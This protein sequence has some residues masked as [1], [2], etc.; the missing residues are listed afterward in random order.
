MPGRRFL[1]GGVP[2]TENPYARFR[3]KPVINASGT[4][5][6][7][8]GCRMFPEAAAAMAAAAGTFVDLDMLLRNTG[9]HIAGLLGVEGALVTA[10]ASPAIIL[11]TAACIAGTDPFLRNR[12]PADPPEKSEVIIMRCHRNPYDNAVPTAGARFVE[13][14]DAIRTHGWE[15][16]GSVNERTAAV[17]FALHAEM[18]DASLSLKETIEIAHGKGVPV[19]VDAAAELPPKANLRD[20]AARGA[21]LVA[22]SGGKDIRGPQASGLL[23]G[24]K[25]LVEAALFNGAPHYGVGR[26]TKASKETVAGFTKALE[27]YLEEDEEARF[28]FWRRV[29]AGWIEELNKMPGIVA[30]VFIPTQPGIHPVNIPKVKFKIE[31]SAEKTEALAARLWNGDPG[32]IVEFGRGYILLNPQVLTEDEARS[33][34]RLVEA[35]LAA[36]RS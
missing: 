16:E 36:A 24:R 27:C 34:P 33:V 32:L 31:G 17:F 21:D 2:M 18:L 12:L 8:G 11:A 20:L 3:I 9:E 6:K 35:G 1:P 13:I 10:G 28:A 15:L 14:G 22:F 7:F 5:T 19:I 26:P 4:M 23:V 29:Q 30:E 25:R